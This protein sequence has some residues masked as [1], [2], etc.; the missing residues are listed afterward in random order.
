[1]E[2]VTALS[3]EVKMLSW[4]RASDEEVVEFRL[5]AIA[6]TSVEILAYWAASSASVK[7]QRVPA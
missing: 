2:S 4:L 1:M 3:L 7:V 5:D 6:S